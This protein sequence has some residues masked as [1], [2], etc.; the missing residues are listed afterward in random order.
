MAI[1]EVTGSIIEE[2]HSILR[3][4]LGQEC[5]LYILQSKK[6]GE[7]YVGTTKDIGIRLDQHNRG[8]G[9][10]TRANSPWRVV[11]REKFNTR[12]EAIRREKEIK[13]QKSRFYIERLIGFH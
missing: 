10:S 11:Y 13:S 7:Y 8:V 9:K 5:F 12:S 6:N 4:T 3:K 2:F 1:G